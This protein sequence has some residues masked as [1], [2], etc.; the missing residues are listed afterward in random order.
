MVRWGLF[1]AAALTAVT[2]V[3]VATHNHQPR[4]LKGTTTGCV[5]THDVGYTADNATHH[6]VSG[7]F[8]RYFSAYVPIGYNERSAGKAN[9]KRWPL[10]IDYHGNGLTPG[11]QY[12]NSQY[13]ATLAGSQYLVVYP[14]GYNLSWQGAGYS[15]PGVN[16]LQFTEDLLAHISQTYCID[17]NRVY[18]SG[19]S[20]GGGFVDLLACSRP[21]GDAFAAFAVASPALYSD[22]SVGECAANTPRAIISSHGDADKVI[23]YAG[24]SGR[25]GILPNI[26]DWVSWWGERNCG[27]GAVPHNSGNLFGYDTTTYSCNGWQNVVEHYQVFNLGHCWPSRTGLN[28]DAQKS[29]DCGDRALGYTEKVLNFFARWDNTTKPQ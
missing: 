26:N 15:W 9:P 21:A 13:F 28:Y 4:G 23:P 29:E 10:I 22:N 7:G 6:I 3:A 2:T 8:D 16:D 1:T 25:G 18:A 27:A 14:Q 5:A 24:G 17:P 20:N 11:D 12:Y 19:K